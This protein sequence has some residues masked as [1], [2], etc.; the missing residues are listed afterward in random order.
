MKLNTNPA[1]AICCGKAR[2]SSSLMPVES[3]LNEGERLYASIWFGNSAWI[4]SANSWASWMSARG[5][6]H[7]DQ[8][9]VRRDRQRL[10]D[11][12]LEAAAHLVEALRGARDVGVPEEV[13]AQLPRLLAHAPER[14]GLGELAPLLG[15]DRGLVAV[16]LLHLQRG[17]H[18]LA[19]GH[20][21]GVGLPSLDH[22]ADDL[23]VGLVDDRLGR[24]LH[25]RRGLLGLLLAARCAQARRRRRSTRRR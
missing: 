21:A 4:A 14:R 24:A 1:S 5:R 7:P 16:L 8:V 22:R 18:G 17:Q 11:G 15:A 9:G 10:A 13:D 25:A 23:V 19:D 20:Q 6:L 12:V 3:Q 2:I